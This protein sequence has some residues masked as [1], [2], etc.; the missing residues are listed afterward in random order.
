MNDASTTK[1]LGA[2]KWLAPGQA[3][4]QLIYGLYLVGFIVPV[5]PIAGIVL[6]YMNH[7]RADGWMETHYDWAIRTF[8]MG[9]VFA[10]C[11]ISA[12]FF[13]VGYAI[14]VA[15]AVWVIVRVVVGLQLAAREQP[16]AHPR[17]IWI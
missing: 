12:L 13:I 5:A 4:I 14:V 2:A 16:I 10:I 11:S 8:W 15:N 6:A 7:D 1:P 9:L 17:S 3:S